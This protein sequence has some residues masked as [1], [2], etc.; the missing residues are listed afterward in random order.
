MVDIISTFG[1]FEWL[2]IVLSVLGL[3]FIIFVI[4]VSISMDSCD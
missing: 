2:D 4:G 3:G 1:F